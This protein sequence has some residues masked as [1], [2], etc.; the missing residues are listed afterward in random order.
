[1]LLT[2]PV[3][4]KWASYGANGD[5]KE[6]LDGE[7]TQ[8]MKDAA[9]IMGGRLQRTP[10]TAAAGTF[11]SG[12]WDEP[13]VL[14]H[15]RLNDRTDADGKRV[16]FVEEIQSDWGQAGKKSGFKGV[17]AID[18]KDGRFF[19]AGNTVSFPTREGAE[20]FYIERNVGVPAAP[21]VGKTDAWVALAIKRVIKM[22]V[23][24]GYD[25]VAFVTGE[26]SAD[27]YD[28]SKQVDSIVWHKNGDGSVAI[29]AQKDG[30]DIHNGDHAPAALPD[31]IGKEL[32]DRIAS[33]TSSSGEFSGLASRSAAR[34]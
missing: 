27:R 25:R 32:A 30:R 33:D 23:D 14:A 24:E 29:A 21:F 3:P 20:A 9:A 19:L 5:L 17:P 16:L 15:I 11:Q 31:V 8:A 18:E 7:P 13:N 12:H 1:M 4:M 2:L 26:Q 34:A 6:W 28:L 22:A 10:L